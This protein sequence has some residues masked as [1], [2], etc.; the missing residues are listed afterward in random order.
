M[1]WLL[2]AMLFLVSCTK[3]V[4]VPVKGND[5]IKTEYKEIIKDSLIYI[6]IEKEA[7]SNTLD[8]HQ[9]TTSF[10]ENSYSTSTAEVTNGTLKHTLETKDNDSI[11]VQIIYKDII[12]TDSVYVTEIVPEKVE[13]PIRDNVFWNSIILN[14][15]LIFLIII[16]IFAKVKRIVKLK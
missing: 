13:V 5:I 7:H 11:P 1:K 2:I 9:D 12:K 16:F 8:A 3:T 14:L 15:V 10:L 6:Q 4:Y